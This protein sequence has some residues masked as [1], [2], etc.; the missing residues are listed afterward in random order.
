MSLVYK[1]NRNKDRIIK[2][3]FKELD[4]EKREQLSLL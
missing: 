3:L 1:K 2:D 4:T